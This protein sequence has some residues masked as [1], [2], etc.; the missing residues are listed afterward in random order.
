MDCDGFGMVRVDM[1][2]LLDFDGVVDWIR[3]MGVCRARRW[4][5]QLIKACGVHVYMWCIDDP[6]VSYNGRPNHL[7]AGLT[8]FC[9]LNIT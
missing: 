8:S 5:K 2:H 3:V 7:S 1:C 9:E 6:I 4:K